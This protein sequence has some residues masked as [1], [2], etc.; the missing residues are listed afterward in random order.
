MVEELAEGDEGNLVH[1]LAETPAVNMGEYPA[2]I[3][4]VEG[5]GLE[6]FVFFPEFAEA[7]PLLVGK[8][9][10][11]FGRTYQMLVAES[12]EFFRGPEDGD[13]DGF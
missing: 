13:V 5:R 6:E 12:L 4:L 9:A 3:L 8:S 2:I 11:K 10:L 7:K 1:F